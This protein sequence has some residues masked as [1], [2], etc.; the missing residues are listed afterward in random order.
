MGK[1]ILATG[2]GR[3]GNGE[4]TETLGMN[5][6]NSTIYAATALVNSVSVTG[7]QADGRI[8]SKVNGKK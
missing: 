6:S 7:F 3:S 8:K 1:L 5:A 4:R 2:P